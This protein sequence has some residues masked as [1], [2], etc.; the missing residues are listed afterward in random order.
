MKHLKAASVLR[1]DLFG[2]IARL[3]NLYKRSKVENINSLP[4]QRTGFT[5]PTQVKRAF[6]LQFRAM[7]EREIF[8]LRAR[9]QHERTQ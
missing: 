4:Y 6:E 7:S 1:T 8:I 3:Q 5:L 2:R 9:A